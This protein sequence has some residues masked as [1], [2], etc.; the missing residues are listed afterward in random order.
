MV[1]PE[2]EKRVSQLAALGIPFVTLFIWS[3]GV[4]DPVNA[5]KLLIAGGVGI[6]MLAIFLCFNFRDTFNSF[7]IYVISILIFILAMGNA[8][9]AS[10]SPLAQNIYG[11]YGRN[12]GLLTYVILSCV[13]LGMLNITS[14]HNFNKLIF[15]LQFAGSIN[16]LYCGWVLAFGDFI[17]WNNPYGDILGCLLYTSPSPR[18]GLL[19]R[20]PSSA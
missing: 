14:M 5:T 1:E 11:S 6:G 8:V 19:S 7:K 15:G 12:T 10:N 17:G 3:S 20:M 16:V 2:V 4:T 18:D 9:V 13:A